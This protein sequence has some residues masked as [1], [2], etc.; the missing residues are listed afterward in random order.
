MYT[1][2]IYNDT[3]AEDFYPSPKDFKKINDFRRLIFILD[4]CFIIYFQNI[5]IIPNKFTRYTLTFLSE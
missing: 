5:Q 1:I 2:E 4:K 3:T